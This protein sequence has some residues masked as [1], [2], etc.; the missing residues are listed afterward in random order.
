MKHNIFVIIIYLL[1]I[2]SLFN[3]INS[4]Q[5]GDPNN[6]PNNDDPNNDP[7][8]NDPNN[9]PNNNDPNNNPN[10]EPE[11]EPEPTPQCILEAE[12]EQRNDCLKNTSNDTYCCFISPLEDDTKPSICYP[13]LKSKYFGYLNINYNKKLYSIDCGIGSTFMDSDW[14]LTLDDKSICGTM[15]PKD[16]KDCIKASTEDNSCC[17]YEGENMKG[18]YWLGIKHQGKV[19]K[20]KYTFVCDGKFITNFIIKLFFLQI[21]YLL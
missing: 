8:N 19:T 11:P 21:L 12:A 9:D 18:C 7:N 17:F 6:N 1:F 4:Q 2:L 3:S 16:Y 15:Y 14:D 20:K 13:F 10:T 5:N